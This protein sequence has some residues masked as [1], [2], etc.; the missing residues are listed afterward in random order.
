MTLEVSL[1]LSLLEAAASVKE[2][3]KRRQP[4]GIGIPD[5]ARHITWFGGH[6]ECCGSRR[7]HGRSP[8]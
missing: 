4:D 3:R 7:F 8:L 6:P 5:T 2:K 1:G